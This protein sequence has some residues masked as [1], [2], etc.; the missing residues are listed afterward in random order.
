[1]DEKKISEVDCEPSTPNG[2]PPN[3]ID[4]DFRRQSQLDVLP[5]KLP[6]NR[7][8]RIGVV[9]KSALVRIGQDLARFVRPVP[10]G[11]EPEVGVRTCSVVPEVFDDQAFRVSR[12]NVSGN[13]VFVPVE[14]AQ[15]FRKA[16]GGTLV[17]DV[18]GRRRWGGV[19]N[20]Y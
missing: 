17:G 19:V 20:N 12:Q 15:E 8:V 13:A 1:M 16:F 3:L 4:R 10:G 5:E 18:D 6:Q 2:N 14:F 9:I 11:P 7:S